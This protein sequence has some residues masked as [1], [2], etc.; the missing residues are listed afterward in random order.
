MTNLI[1]TLVIGGVGIAAG[2]IWTIWIKPMRDIY[3]D[4]KHEI[5]AYNKA[6]A[7]TKKAH[8]WINDY[9]EKHEGRELGL[10][11]VSELLDPF[12][13]SENISTEVGDRVLTSAIHETKK[14]EGVTLVAN[15]E[16]K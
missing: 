16:K 15:E 11:I 2:I 9:M 12:V 14:N 1:W 10:E 6:K 3:I 7:L 8:D 13:D 5:I 4:E